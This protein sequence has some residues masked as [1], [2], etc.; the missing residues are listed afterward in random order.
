[1][2]END[3]QNVSPLD[4]LLSLLLT[5]QVDDRHIRTQYVRSQMENNGYTENEFHAAV[6]E[7]MVL[8]LVKV[9]R[10]FGVPLSI[11]LTPLAFW[12]EAVKNQ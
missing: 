8:D 6:E 11:K 1:M 9:Y 4:F 2:L 7:G 3:T 10:K 12:I 5:V